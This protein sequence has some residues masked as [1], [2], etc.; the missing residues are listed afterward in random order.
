MTAAANDTEMMAM[1]RLKQK[2]KFAGKLRK[3]FEDADT[4]GDG[5]ISADEMEDAM[6]KP[7]V[8]ACLQVL[9]LEVFE[10]TALFKLLDDGDGLVSFEEFV[11]GAMR[12]KGNARA[13]DSIAIMHETNKMKSKIERLQRDVHGLHRMQ[14][15]PQR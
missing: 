7:T 1:T 12:L 11:A 9:E 4:S 2:E 6:K 15:H 13:I 10:V 5:L 14:D 8:M 3:F